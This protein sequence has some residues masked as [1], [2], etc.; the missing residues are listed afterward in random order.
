MVP[1]RFIAESLGAEVKWE[2]ATRK[3]SYSFRGIQ[4]DLWIGKKNAEV[5]DATGKKRIV[6]LL[7]EP[8]IVS[9][10]TLV[11]LRF[12]SEAMGAKV[13]WDPKLWEAI[14]SFPQ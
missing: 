11:P 10:R 3:V 6:T 4:V 12:V 13:D 14:I 5:T 1:F 7:A 2:E 8:E 9:G